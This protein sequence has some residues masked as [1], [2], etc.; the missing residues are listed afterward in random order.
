MQKKR[1]LRAEMRTK[2]KTRK[3]N[4][5]KKKRTKKENQRD[6][7]SSH[8]PYDGRTCSLLDKSS[9]QKSTQNVPDYRRSLTSCRHFVVF[10]TNMIF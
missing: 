6:Q 3:W 8:S 5:K 1:E 4:Q 7:N 2:K 10:L 9:Q